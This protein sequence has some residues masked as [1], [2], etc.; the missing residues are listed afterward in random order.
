MTYLDELAA[1]IEQEVPAELL[2]AGNTGLL[3][4]LYAVLLLAKGGE[5]TAQDVHNAWAAWMQERSPHHRSIKPFGKLDART[6]E[7]DEPFAQAIRSVA[8][9]LGLPADLPA[10]KYSAVAGREIEV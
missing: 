1:K 4:R 9:R 3:F 2:P 8:S 10:G 7:S 6:Q 5:V